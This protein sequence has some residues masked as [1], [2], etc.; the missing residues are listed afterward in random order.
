[1]IDMGLDSFPSFQRGLIRAQWGVARVG[2]CWNVLERK[3][4][5]TRFNRLAARKASA[6]ADRTPFSGHTSRKLRL[7]GTNCVPPREAVVGRIRSPFSFGPT[8]VPY[9]RG[10]AATETAVHA[11]SVWNR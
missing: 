9:S 6:L 10:R 7:D 8:P 2:E 5:S 4:G 1:M 11:L 3:F